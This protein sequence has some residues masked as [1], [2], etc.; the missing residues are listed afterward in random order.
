MSSKSSSSTPLS[1]IIRFALP[2]PDLP[3]TIP[4]PST[5]TP[6]HLL[7]Q[8]IRPHLPPP[9][10]SCPIRLI[11][12]GALLSL[13]TPLS[14]LLRLPSTNPPPPP[15]SKGKAPVPFPP[16]P[17]YMHCSVSTTQTLSSA[18]L[19]AEAAQTFTTSSSSPSSPQTSSTSTFTSTAQHAPPR[20]A[21][22]PPLGFDRLLTTGFS[23]TEIASLRSQLLAL[24][25][26]THTPDT[27]PSPTAMRRLEERWL[28][29]TSSTPSAPGINSDDGG[30]EG[31]AGVNDDEDDDG[32]GALEDM[33]WGNLMGFFW[34]VGAAV[35]LLREE[36]VWSKRRQVAAVTGLF[37]N[38]AF[39][40][41]RV[42]G[43]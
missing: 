8:H 28:D 21:D 15:S 5:T 24:T 17:I 10:R 43:G 37:V 22:D 42:G 4:S 16:P 32:R 33:L 11:T 7:H 23:P 34:P 14:S 9:Y 18:A 40:V 39:G 13:T 38:L 3:L 1:L 20:Q 29:N 12:S 25:A 41:M 6:L 27:M 30:L 2:I 26:H 35:W 19:A 36:G 31:V